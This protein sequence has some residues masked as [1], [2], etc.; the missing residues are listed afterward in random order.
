MDLFEEITTLRNLD[1][2]FVLATVV[3]VE[4]PVSAKPGAKAVIT[5]PGVLHGWIGGSCTEPTVLHEAVKVLD[6]GTPR[7]IRILPPEKMGVYPQEGVTE[8]T[9]TCASGGT[10]EIYL[11]PYQTQPHLVVMGHQAIAEALVNLGK[12]LDYRV[13]VIGENLSKDR[14]PL[15]DQV[16]DSLDFSQFTFTPKTFVVVTSHGNYDEPAL[17]AALAS[18][19][20]YVALVASKKRAESIREYLIGAGMSDQVLGRLKVP[21][22]LDLG[23]ISPQ[24]I[25]LSILAEIIQVHRSRQV[26]DLDQKNVQS[27]IIAETAIDPVCGMT[28]EISSA[29]YVFAYKNM[30]VYFCSAHCLHLFQKEPEQYLQSELNA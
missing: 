2:P 27:E 1:E 26:I 17:E 25:A 21:A 22:G 20:G 10:L 3:R 12:G 24:E 7:L 18:P 8:V 15:A 16:I 19:A 28:V 13:S 14:F 11:E 29:R 23:S 9:L 4:K 30:K 6:T 5:R